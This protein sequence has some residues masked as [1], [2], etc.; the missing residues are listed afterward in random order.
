VW[1]AYASSSSSNIGT[2]IVAIIGA[3]ATVLVAL[4]GGL[5][6]FKGSARNTDL[7]REKAFDSQ[8]DAELNRLRTRN[9][10]LEQQ[11]DR[12]IAKLQRARFVFVQHN[13]DPGLIDR[14]ASL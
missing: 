4:L 8:V 5:F 12:L 9:E 11:N 6:T 7:E 1:T 2:I 13:L 14:E 10:A 3:A